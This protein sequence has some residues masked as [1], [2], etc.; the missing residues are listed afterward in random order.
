VYS[1]TG[2]AIA[3]MLPRGYDVTIIARDMPADP[4]SYQWS[5]PWAGAVWMATVK[6]TLREQKMQLQAFSYLW[7]LALSDPESGVRVSLIY[8]G[9]HP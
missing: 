6:S 1:I 2:L 8:A 4:K 9:I 5:S 7:K 3:S